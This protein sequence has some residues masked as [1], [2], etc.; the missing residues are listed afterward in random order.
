MGRM[1]LTVNERGNWLLSMTCVTRHHV[2][3]IKIK[4]R[5][6]KISNEQRLTRLKHIPRDWPEIRCCVCSVRHWRYLKRKEK[7]KKISI[8]SDTQNKYFGNCYFQFKK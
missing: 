5:G 6:K 1:K 8:F 7:K 3:K 4:W 2:K